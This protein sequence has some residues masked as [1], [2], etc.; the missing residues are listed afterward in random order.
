MNVYATVVDL[1][2]RPLYNRLSR[3]PSLPLL[4][5]QPGES[6]ALLKRKRYIFLSVPEVMLAGI[7]LWMGSTTTSVIDKLGYFGIFILMVLESMVFPLPSELVMPFAGYLA[8]QGRFTFQFV[9]VASVCGSIVGSFI[10]YV[11]GAYGGR[12]LILKHGKY[13]LVTHHDLHMTES[14]FKKRGEITIFLARFVPVVRHLISIPAGI[15]KMNL[16][17]FF[18]YTA[19]GAGLWNGFLAWLGY[20]FGEHWDLVRKYTEPFSIVIALMIVGAVVW[21]IW[22]HIKRMKTTSKG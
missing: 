4:A 8:S 6:S 17:K 13:I 12:E 16:W 14:W 19:V 2:H 18:I 22:R 21:Y 11:I 9:M 10:S 7:M 1:S 5:D 3:K 15:A 20:T